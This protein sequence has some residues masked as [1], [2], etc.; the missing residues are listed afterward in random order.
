MTVCAVEDD[1]SAGMRE[2]K[3]KLADYFIEDFDEILD[4]K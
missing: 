3:S 4:C 1:F 2:E